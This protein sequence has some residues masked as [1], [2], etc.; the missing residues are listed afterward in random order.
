MWDVDDK[1]QVVVMD[2]K[3]WCGMLN[4]MG[5]IDVITFPFQ[6]HMVFLM[7]IIIITRLETTILLL[8]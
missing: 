6:N 2:F 8:R 1:M 3:N 4:I 7:K 5:A